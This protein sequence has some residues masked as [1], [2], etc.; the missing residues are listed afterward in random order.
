MSSPQAEIDHERAQRVL[1]GYVMAYPSAADEV[2][3][4]FPRDKS[5]AFSVPILKKIFEAIHD[6]HEREAKISP[7]TIVTEFRRN[8]WGTG[9]PATT[10]VDCADAAFEE[11]ETRQLGQSVS[12]YVSAVL[13]GHYLGMMQGKA[14]RATSFSGFVQ[15]AEEAIALDAGLGGP[16]D[17]RGEI[18]PVL[19][20]VL[21]TQE[22]IIGALD[23]VIRLRTGKLY[24]GAGQ[25]GSGKTKFLLSVLHANVAQQ[26]PVPCLLF[27]LEMDRAEVGKMLLSREANID[28]SLIFTRTLVPQLMERLR[29]ARQRLAKVPLEVDCTPSLSVAQIVSRI[30]HWKVRRRIPAHTGIVGVDFLQLIALERERGQ[31]SEATA[32]KNTAYALAQAAKSFQVC[33]VSLAQLNKQADDVEPRIGFIEGSGGLAQASQGVLLLDLP[34]LR[35]PKKAHPAD[36]WDE[37]NIIVAK[38]RDGQSKVTV[39]AQVDLSIGKFVGKTKALVLPFRR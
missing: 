12:D 4:A 8:R 17:Y 14:A 6:L 30:R 23:D 26:E 10:F 28:S 34:R 1:L 13:S 32:L 15:V 29:L 37:V 22:L 2:L 18:G 24:T 36:G 21:D 9:Q 19:D 20:E 38:N 33:I 11:F 25:K 3:S 16:E 35:E 39:E 27:S 31:L 7:E 5:A